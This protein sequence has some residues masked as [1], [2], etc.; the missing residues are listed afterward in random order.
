MR[1]PSLNFLRTLANTPSP[2]GYEA[3][4]QR[5]WLDYIKEFADDTFSDAYGNCVATLNK[6]GSPR[7][8]LAAHADEIA[9]AVN[10]IS[11]EG[12]IYVRKI[13]GVDAAI[14]KAQR[15]VIHSQAGPVAGVVGNVAPHL[16]RDSDEK[17]IPP[18]IHE[19][20]IDIGARHRKDAEKLARIGD[21][22]TLADEFDLL[23]NDLAVARAF[24]N[25]IGTFAVAETLRLLKASKSKPRAEVCAVSNVQ[26]EGGLLGARQ[27]A[28]S[29]KPDIALVVDVTH[30][31]DYPTV[32][33][34]RHGD[35][36][37]G[38]G[39]VVTHGASNHPE[40]V[41]R[42][43]S[44]ARRK[45]IPLQHQAASSNTG[46]DTDVIFWTRGGIASA[47]VSLPNRY[48]HSPVEVVNLKDLEKIPELLAA[49]VASVKAG[50]AFKVKI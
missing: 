27:I 43:E 49:F 6:G 22:I 20:F 46:T 32:Q 19:L 16:Y 21:P 44:V 25:R 8:M 50:E 33:K 40:V 26:E 5:V 45:K 10:Y 23:R 18:K 47:L 13:G 11:E 7:V 28:Y 9:L 15:V 3:R 12:F 37:L 38:G 48:M 17:P 31:T 29:L 4:G 34:T 14:T 35:I 39:P 30:A 1:E 36:K 24:D 42:L 41:G 2:V